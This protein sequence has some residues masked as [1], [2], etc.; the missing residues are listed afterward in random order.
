[1]SDL[2]KIFEELVIDWRGSRDD[3]DSSSSMCMNKA[4]QHI[5]GMG[6][7]AIPLILKELERKP[8]W[9]FW[10]LKAISREDPVPEAFRGNLALMTRYWLEWGKNQGYQW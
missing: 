3:L 10:A 8:D 5:I 1:M 9:W 7:Y 6:P 4:Y 2:T